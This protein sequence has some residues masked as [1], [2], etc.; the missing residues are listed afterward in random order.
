MFAL[1]TSVPFLHYVGV[2]SIP[3]WMVQMFEVNQGF[4]KSGEF[5]TETLSHRLK[6]N[7]AIQRHSYNFE[8]TIES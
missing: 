6:S 1:S 3:I 2:Q 8:A 5:I 4:Q 7:V